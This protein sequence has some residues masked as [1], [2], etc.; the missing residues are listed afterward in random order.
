MYVCRS[1]FNS[2]VGNERFRGAISISY[3]TC[4]LHPEVCILS[5]YAKYA[6]PPT[7]S[8]SAWAMAAKT[9]ERELKRRFRCKSSTRQAF[10][11]IVS[12]YSPWKK[13]LGMFYMQLRF[14]ICACLVPVMNQTPAFCSAGCRVP[15]PSFCVLVAEY[16]HPALWKAGVWFTRLLHVYVNICTVKLCEV[17]YCTLL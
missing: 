11:K 15:R 6:A 17:F 1:H 10:L 14:I 13:F 5:I 4:L 9:L 16:M 12:T 2:G 7:K 3:C 8:M